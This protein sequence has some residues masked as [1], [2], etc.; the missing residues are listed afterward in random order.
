M[1]HLSTRYDVRSICIP[2]SLNRFLKATLIRVHM[3]FNASYG[4][5]HD[6]VES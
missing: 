3:R 4:K 2:V 5:M 6:M 1:I